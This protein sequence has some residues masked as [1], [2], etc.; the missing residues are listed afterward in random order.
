MERVPL[1]HAA[2][3]RGDDTERQRLISTATMV[4]FRLSDHF[5]LTDTVNQMAIAKFIDVV[6]MASQ[7]LECSRVSAA[8]SD[9]ENANVP[10]C[11][12]PAASFL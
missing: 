1:I 7:F 10:L 2:S 6:D 4:H 5:A 8:W 3:A 9:D 12:F 11:R